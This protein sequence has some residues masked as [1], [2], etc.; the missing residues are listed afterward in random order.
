MDDEI[1][2]T[3]NEAA[4]GDLIAGG[5]TYTYGAGGADSYIVRTDADGNFLWESYFGFPQFEF[6]NSILSTP[7]DGILA[8]GITGTSYTDLDIYIIKTDSEG[9]LVWDRVYDHSPHLTANEIIPTFSG[10]YLLTGTISIDGN[11]NMYMAE[12]EDGE[13]GD[14]GFIE[15]NVNLNG[16]GNVE[17]V[18]IT[19]GGGLTNP[20]ESG[21]YTLEVLP[22]TYNITTSMAG[23]VS[24]TNYNV[25]VIEGETT[26]N[27][28]FTL[29]YVTGD[30]YGTVTLSGGYGNVVDVLIEAEDSAGNLFTGNPNTLGDYSMAIIPGYYDVTFSLDGYISQTIE[31]VQVPEGTGP[32][33]LN[34]TLVSE[35]GTDDNVVNAVFSLKQNYPNPFNPTTLISFS[36]PQTSSFVDLEIFNMKGQKIKTLIHSTLAQGN[37]NVVWNGMDDNNQPVSSGMYLYKLKNGSYTSTKKMILMK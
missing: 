20:D 36:V 8:A 27:I 34:I 35:V 9:T 4:N 15:G 6:V 32:Y 30:L 2:E 18:V 28:D 10:N 17:D 37:H 12:I 16:A 19:G 5:A 26:S 33:A 3:V 29:G 21:N 11:L 24:Q 7:D 22:G 31:E 1:F 14:P 23:Y 13:P 25:V